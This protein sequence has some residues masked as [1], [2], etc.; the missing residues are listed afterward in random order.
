MK[1]NVETKTTANKV[2]PQWGLKGF[3]WT[4]VQ[5]LT[6]VLRLNVCAKYPRLRQYPYRY[7]KPAR[8]EHFAQRLQID[9]N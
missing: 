8:F 2:L 3:D 9:C 5:G 6:F 7:A 1:S 4:F